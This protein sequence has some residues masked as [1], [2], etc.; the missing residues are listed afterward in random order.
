MLDPATYTTLLILIIV[1]LV[2]MLL[3]HAFIFG[4]ILILLHQ[5]TNIPLWTLLPTIM[6]CAIV[7]VSMTAEKSRVALS[8]G[9]TMVYSGAVTVIALLLALIGVKVIKE[10]ILR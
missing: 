3:I 4:F 9:E 1:V 6:I 8:I 5:K 7:A 10:K 2:S